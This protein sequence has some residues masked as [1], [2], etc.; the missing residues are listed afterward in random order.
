[1]NTSEIFK[2]FTKQVFSEEI[3]FDLPKV[4]DEF[5]VFYPDI[6]KIIQKDESFFESERIVFGR[7]LSLVENREAIWNNLPACMFASFL[8]GDIR[9]KVDKVSSLIKNIWN[10]SGQENDDI[11]KILNDEASQGKFDE[12]IEFVLNS[13]IAK[14]FKNLME[15]I[16]LSEFELNVE[17]A[18]Q[19]IELIKNPE[20]PTIKRM[21]EKIQGTIQDKIKRGEINQNTIV[22]E[23]EAIKAKVM[24][25]FGNMFN[26]A[27][28]GRKADVPNHVLMGNTPEAR[29]QRMLARLQRKFNEKNSK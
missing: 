23:I 2:E 6:V 21:I 19:V 8:H 17:S 9:K 15:S 10:A 7:N 13:R 3:E 16:D 25:L 5:E 24:S 4:V 11:T 12:L 28:G 26:E 22:N 20:N 27:L 29:R 18:E 14:I 1:M